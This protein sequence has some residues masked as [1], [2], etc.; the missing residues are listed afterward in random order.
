MGSYRRK[1]YKKKPMDLFHEKGMGDMIK[2]EVN[3]FFMG[4]EESDCIV[5][6]VEYLPMVNEPDI[7]RELREEERLGKLWTLV[8]DIQKEEKQHTVPGLSKRLNTSEETES[9][10]GQIK[11]ASYEDAL[12][13]AKKALMKVKES[14][15]E[16]T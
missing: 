5:M 1:S 11:I 3:F 15:N 2:D 7:V 4:K 12:A 10:P 14:L 13:L 6:D 8:T 16:T 9:D